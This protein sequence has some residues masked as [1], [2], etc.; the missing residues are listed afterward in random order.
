MS[1]IICPECGHEIST[2]ATAC[3]NCGFTFVRSNQVIGKRV[4]V[5]EKALNNNVPTWVI[6]PLSVVGIVVLFLIVSLLRNNDKNP[7]NA[8]ISVNLATKPKVAE[9]RE[10]AVQ[11]SSQT[12]LPSN[13]TVVNPP[14]AAD[15]PKTQQNVPPASTTEVNNIQTDKSVVKINAKISNKKGEIQSVKN[16]KFYLLDKDLESILAEAELEP[17]EGNSLS[18]SFG[19]SVMYPERYREFNRQSLE[20]INKYI[21]YNALTDSEG[22]ASMKDVK[23]ENY[24]LFGITKTKS[25]FAIWNSPVNILAGENQLNLSPV[26]LNEM[27]G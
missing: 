27:A 14:T 17:I 3:P 7:D 6:V 20:A 25:G 5:A 18:N 4:I 16:E 8:N 22:K 19:L 21:K 2:T 15:V 10:V 26:S 13:P 1:L 9:P 23:P 11:P 12:S 24:Y